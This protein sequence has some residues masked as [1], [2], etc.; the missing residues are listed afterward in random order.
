MIRLAAAHLDAIRAAAEDAYPD[1]CCGLLVGRRGGADGV[2]VTAV[3]ASR[4]VVAGDARQRFEIDP[5]LRLRV[6]R[7]LEGGGE[8]IVGLYHSHPDHSAEPSARD[9][10]MAYEPDLVWVIAA[11]AQGRAAEVRGYRLDEVAGRFR[12]MAILPAAA[13]APAP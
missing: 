10:A 2:T 9:L 11:V 3:E 8:E 12:E 4:N 5:E 6:M 7:R 13:G 1:E